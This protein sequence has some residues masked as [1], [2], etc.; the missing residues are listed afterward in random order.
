MQCR[1]EFDMCVTG[2]LKSSAPTWLSTL[3]V[4]V[5]TGE[6]LYD[7]FVRRVPNIYDFIIRFTS[8]LS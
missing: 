1:P 7:Y 2:E 6:P 5:S 3:S 4:L 8:L